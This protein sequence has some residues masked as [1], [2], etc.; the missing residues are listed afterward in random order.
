MR[1]YGSNNHETILA[2]NL[3]FAKQRILPYH[4]SMRIIIPFF[5]IA[6]LVGFY[7]GGNVWQS[8]KT[9]VPFFGEKQIDLPDDKEKILPPP[10]PNSPLNNLR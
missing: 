5:I 7:Y 9:S 8:I 1:F 6:L 10:S 3:D 4:K 2:K